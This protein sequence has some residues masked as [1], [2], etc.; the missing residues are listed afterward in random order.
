MDGVAERLEHGIAV[1]D[2]GCG[3]GASTI[4]MAQTYPRSRF[5]GIDPHD[6]S[7]EAARKHAADAGVT[8]RI[9][10]RAGDREAADRQLRPH[11]LLR[12]PARP[13]RPGR[14]AADGGRAP[15][16]RRRRARSS[17]RTPATPCRDNLN[18][19]G[20][21]YYGFSTLLCTPNAL[22]QEAATVAR[23]AGR[24]GADRRGGTPRRA[25]AGSGGSPRRRST[26]CSSCGADRRHP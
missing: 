13:R 14:C 19:V 6:G 18:P 26:W 11:R 4:H 9:D 12:L 3:H 7:I 8:E 24:R 23:H 2:I 5:I 16:R 1:A 22:A 15:G 10:V 21:A 25:S 20:A 17:S